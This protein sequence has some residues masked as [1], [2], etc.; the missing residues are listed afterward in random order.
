MPIAESAM[1][2]IDCRPRLLG[3][4]LAI[5]GGW[6]GGRARADEVDGGQRFETQIAPLLARRC[7]E[8]HNGADKKG[9]LDLT[10]ADTT[11][12]GGDSGTVIVARSPD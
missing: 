6:V 10:Q 1:F 12:A 7:L 3:L 5:L 8:C 11:I 2:R 9:G 4:V